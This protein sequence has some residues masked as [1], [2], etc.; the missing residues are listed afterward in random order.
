M[1]QNDEESRLEFSGDSEDIKRFI[2]DVR[3]KHPNI[4]KLSSSYSKEASTGEGGLEL[5]F[6]F[7]TEDGEIDV[8][9][10]ERT[11]SCATIDEAEEM[12]IMKHMTIRVPQ[13]VYDKGKHQEVLDL[14]KRWIGDA[15]IDVEISITNKL[16]MD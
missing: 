5:S 16:E 1:A 14:T 9:Y 11:P 12:R 10:R 7:K 8:S 15:G 13:A 4:T 6:T 3:R 2:A